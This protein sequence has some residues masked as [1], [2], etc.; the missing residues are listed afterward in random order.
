MC[1]KISGSTRVIG[2]PLT[3]IKP[4]PCLTCATAVAFFFLPKVY[5][6]KT[7]QQR[8]GPS[9]GKGKESSD[10]LVFVR[11]G[12]SVGAYWKNSRRRMCIS[13]I[14]CGEFGLEGLDHCESTGLFSLG[15]TSGRSCVF[16]GGHI[17][18]RI[19]ILAD[20]REA[21][22]LWSFPFCSLRNVL[23]NRC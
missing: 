16:G 5:D 19:S 6:E 7:A 22:F 10:L 3:L 23:W 17:G 8:L 9:V 12:C 18:W 21:F 13:G 11:F 15:S 1:L 14:R 2:Q 4:L 20:E